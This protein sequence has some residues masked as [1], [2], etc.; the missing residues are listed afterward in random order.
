MNDSVQITQVSFLKESLVNGRHIYVRLN[1][2]SHF[3]PFFCFNKCTILA[4]LVELH[5]CNTKFTIPQV[6]L[7]VY[8]RKITPEQVKEM[9]LLF[10]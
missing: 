3:Q 8:S 6:F 4:V 9:G 10:S 7:V 2:L 1:Y 5:S